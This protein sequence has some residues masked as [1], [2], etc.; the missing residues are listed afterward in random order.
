MVLGSKWFGALTGLLLFAVLLF[1][2]LMP[3]L[4]GPPSPGA[5]PTHGAVMGAAFAQLPAWVNVW[6]KF[7]DVIIAASLF[8]ILWRKEAQI[9]AWGVIANHLFLFPVMPLV[10]IEKLTLG[11]A[12]LSHYF[13]IIPLFVLV[14][15]WPKLDK[16][17]GYGTWVTVAIAQLIFSLS[18]DIPQGA[19]FLL[20][21]FS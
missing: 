3:Y 11:F 18:F 12:A 16:A 17:T 20:S 5:E 21:L 13:W 7:Q 15:A 8:F 14:K 4:G 6:M 9:Y 2:E 1:I 10:P 19:A